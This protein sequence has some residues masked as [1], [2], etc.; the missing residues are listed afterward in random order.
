[1]SQIGRTVPEIWHFGSDYLVT[2]ENVKKLHFG[3]SDKMKKFHEISIKSSNLKY[4]LVGKKNFKF[5]FPKS[6]EKKI[7][8]KNWKKNLDFFFNCSSILAKLNYLHGFFWSCHN[9]HNCTKRRDFF[10]LFS[11]GYPGSSAVFKKQA[12]WVWQSLSRRCLIPEF[13]S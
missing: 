10:R 6:L 4:F 9:N 8:L 2:L 12:T 3:I 7:F 11:G 1:M 5:S 13:C